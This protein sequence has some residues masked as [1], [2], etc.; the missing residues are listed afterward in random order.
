MQRRRIGLAQALIND[1]D[2][3]ILDEPTSGLDPIGTRQFKDLIL[4]LAERGKT[5]VLSSHL[6]ADVEDVCDRVCIL[7]G[8]KRRAVG[9]I[10]EL[11]A[12]QERT[13]IVTQDLSPE[14]LEAVRQA[15]RQGGQDV[16]EV[17]KPRDRLENLFLRIVDEARQQRL[18]TGGAEAGGK[19]AE[20]LTQPD[21][22]DILESLVASAETESEPVDEPA[23]A[24]EAPAEHVDEDVVKQL[25]EPEPEVPAEPTP[26]EAPAESEAPRREGG[27]D[28]GVLDGL[29]SDGETETGR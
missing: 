15:V 22:E 14:T 17:R 23:E 29:L 10:D 1:P 5:V 21:E 8:G 9:S 25:V 27:V 28:R 4:M 13:E 2:L 6:L 18:K 3:L 12:V 7:Y 16:L 20:F 11:L 26:T 19:L 24:P